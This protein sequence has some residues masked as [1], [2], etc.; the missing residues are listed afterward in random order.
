MRPALRQATRRGGYTL[1][2]LLVTILL[3]TVTMGVLTMVFIMS[4]RVNAYESSNG[5]L[6]LGNRVAIDEMV[7]QIRQATTVAAGNG[8][9]TTSA[10]VLVLQLA[11]V[12]S[13]NT[14]IPATYDYI[15]FKLDATQ[16]TKLDEIIVSAVG[17]S[18][19]SHTR[20]ITNDVDT[21]T[22]AFTDK[23]GAT[24]TSGYTA[25]KKIKIQLNTSRTNSGRKTI[26]NYSN[27]A[28]LRNQ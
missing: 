27:Q 9:N 6:Q 28:S 24:L 10:N 5:Q 20:A 7:R 19:I 15:I 26:I 21:L 4:F 16:P 8:S 18:R 1:I 13:S 17:S 2:E 3:V 14:I 11:S 23:T 25:T 22:F 12:N